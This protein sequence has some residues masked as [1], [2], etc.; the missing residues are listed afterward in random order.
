MSQ[1]LIELAPVGQDAAQVV[2]GHGQVGVDFECLLAVYQGL[3]EP[4]P[5]DQNAAQA[6]VSQGVVGVE[7]QRSLKVR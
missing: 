6:L 2:L 4:A 5:S 7:F 3:V 1:G